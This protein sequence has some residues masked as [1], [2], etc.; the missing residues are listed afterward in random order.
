[1]PIIIQNKSSL[2]DHACM[3]IRCQGP[4]CSTQWNS[5]CR[6]NTSEWT[7]LSL[8]YSFLPD[9]VIPTRRVL[10]DLCFLSVLTLGTHIVVSN[11]MARPLQSN[12]LMARGAIGTC[13][14][15]PSSKT[16][17]CSYGSVL[18]PGGGS[19]AIWWKLGKDCSSESVDSDR[20]VMASSISKSATRKNEEV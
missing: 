16:T 15:S 8:F 11:E 14:P 17:H 1:M 12:A 6:V 2:K 18:T 20:I 19:T 3:Q 9:N 4:A 7:K 5:A 13:L 10:E